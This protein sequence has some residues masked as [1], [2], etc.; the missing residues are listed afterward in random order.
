[1]YGTINT[2]SCIQVLPPTKL[3]LM[4]PDILL[5]EVNVAVKKLEKKSPGKHTIS[6]EVVKSILIYDINVTHHLCIYV[7][8]LKHQFSL[9]IFL[10]YERVAPQPFFSIYSSHL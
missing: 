6:G 7:V 3:T 10:C 1:M 5:E 8:S 9:S 2:K 4:K